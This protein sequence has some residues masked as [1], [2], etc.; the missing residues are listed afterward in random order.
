MMADTMLGIGDQGLL[1]D[2]RTAPATAMA[3]GARY[4]EILEGRHSVYWELPDQ[5]NAALEELLAEAYA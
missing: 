2:M 1:D 5:F 4:V 3:P